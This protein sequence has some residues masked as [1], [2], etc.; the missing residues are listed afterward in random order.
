[1]AAKEYPIQMVAF[2]WEIKG[3]ESKEE[4]LRTVTRR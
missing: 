3:E 2:V 4:K 1:M